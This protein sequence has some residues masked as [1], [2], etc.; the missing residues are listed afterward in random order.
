MCG[1]DI[2]GSGCE[3]L[4]AKYD[5]RDNF[6]HLF[7][8]YETILFFEGL[9]IRLLYYRDYL[10]TFNHDNRAMNEYCESIILSFV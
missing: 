6:S 3:Q 4:R 8:F 2:F 7:N 10:V 9:V 1:K 5:K